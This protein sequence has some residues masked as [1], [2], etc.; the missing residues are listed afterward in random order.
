M[1]R[2][3]ALIVIG[4]FKEEWNILS[5]TQQNDFVERVGRTANALA[6]EPI[7][8]YRLS[9]TP[10]A[11]MQVWEANTREAIDH[12]V[13]NLEALGYTRYIDARWLIGE[14]DTPQE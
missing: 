1:R 4:R 13:K 10:G 14:R 6:L 11:F 2:K 5:P 9:S 8:G 12:A 7:A 3:I